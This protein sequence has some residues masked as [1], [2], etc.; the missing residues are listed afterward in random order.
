L[1]CAVHATLP[2]GLAGMLPIPDGGVC[3]VNAPLYHGGPFLFGMLPA[4]RGA[5]LVM[6]RRFDPAEM[7]RLVDGYGVTTAYAVPTHFVRLLRLPDDVKTAFDG[8]SLQAVF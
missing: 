1:P 4:Y 8:S 7:L 2:A 6:R 3:L 5:T